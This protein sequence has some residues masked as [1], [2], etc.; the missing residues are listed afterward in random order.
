M[1]T[2]I[3]ILLVVLSA[4]ANVGCRSCHS[5]GAGCGAAQPLAATAESTDSYC[6]N[7]ACPLRDSQP[8]FTTVPRVPPNTY[9]IDD[10]T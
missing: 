6:P 3:A 10:A 1:R 5:C 2:G 7:G 9:H 8:S 4:A